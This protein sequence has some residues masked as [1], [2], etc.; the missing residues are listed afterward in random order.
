[1]KRKEIYLTDTD[2]R[3]LKG[4]LA[5][6]GKLD[7]RDERNLSDLQY[8]LERAKVVPAAEIP[9]DVVTMNTRFRLR[10]ID[11]GLIAEYT[12]VF[13][14]EADISKGYLSILAPIGTALLGYRELDTVEWNVPAGLKRFRVE[15]VLYQP[16]AEAARL[17]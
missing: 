11:T 3:R 17:V 10:D 15:E 13:P 12:L 6:K 4:L 7:G 14:G 2:Q 5:S 8:E 9:Q 1:M 16:E